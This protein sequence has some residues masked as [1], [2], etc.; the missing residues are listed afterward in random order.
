LLSASSAHAIIGKN[1]SVVAE[2]DYPQVCKVEILDQEG[3]DDVRVCTGTLISSHEVLTAAHC[4]GRDFDLKK[5]DVVVHCG[6]VGKADV[7]AIQLPSAKVSS[8]WLNAKE[9]VREKDAAVILFKSEFKQKSAIQITSADPYF[10]SDGNLRRS[11]KC[12]ILGFGKSGNGA[13]GILSQSDL[14]NVTLHFNRENGLLQVTAKASLFLETSVD[15][16]DSG[17]PLFCTLNDG[18]PKLLATAI[19][20]HYVGA[21]MNRDLNLAKPVWLS[22]ISVNSETHS[23]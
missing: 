11:A 2:R 9:P 16:G 21:T 17:A 23:D 19:L 14:S 5:S 7:T 12:K 20:Y 3:A 15:V 10:D 13:N 8:N 18:S 22:K 1:V 4:F 6:E